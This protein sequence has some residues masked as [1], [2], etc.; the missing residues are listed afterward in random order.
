MCI[1]LENH[2]GD[3]V[4]FFDFGCF[5]D[6]VFSTLAS[7]P[8]CCIFSTLPTKLYDPIFST[9]TTHPIFSTLVDPPSH[10]DRWWV[11]GCIF[12]C[13]RGPRPGPGPGSRGPGLALEPG[14]P[15]AHQKNAAT[16]PPPRR[17]IIDDSS[18][19]GQSFNHT[20]NHNLNHNSNH[21][22]NNCSP[23][24]PLRPSLFYTS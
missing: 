1:A 8:M 11:G 7:K 3:Y 13:A 19:F 22:L 18:I 5:F 20:P 16:N 12:W 6:F 2:G 21:N 4:Y 15:R 10:N 17:E 9:F 23:Y 14:S 24:V